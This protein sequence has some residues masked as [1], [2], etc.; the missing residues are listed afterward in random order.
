MPIE[1]I[2]QNADALLRAIECPSW[3]SCRMQAV[4]VRNMIGLK[5]SRRCQISSWT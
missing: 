5:I 2:D 1:V 4:N 3:L